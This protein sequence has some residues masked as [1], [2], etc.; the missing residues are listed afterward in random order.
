M[1]GERGHEKQGRGVKLDSNDY[2]ELCELLDV[3]FELPLDF[4]ILKKSFAF[5]HFR[6]KI[7]IKKD[8]Y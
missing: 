2:Q 6:W 7:E 8:T 1:C 3:E 5:D 4:I